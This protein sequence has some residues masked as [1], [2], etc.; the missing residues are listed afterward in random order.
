MKQGKRS[1]GRFWILVAMYIVIVSDSEAGKGARE[2]IPI[3]Q[4]AYDGDVD[5]VEKLIDEGA[6]VNAL[7]GEKG[8]T[9]LLYACK[10]GSDEVADLLLK[11]G[12]KMNYQLPWRQYSPLML[13]VDSGNT[14]VVYLLL[15]SGADPNL[16]DMYG[17]TALMRARAADRSEMVTQLQD[18]GAKEIDAI[19][20]LEELGISDAEA[21]RCEL[22]ELTSS[23]RKW[24]AKNYE[25]YK[26]KHRP[27]WTEIMPY[28]DESL[29]VYVRSGKDL[30]GNKIVFNAFRSG[31][32]PVT[33]SPKSAAS[34]E[35]VLNGKEDSKSFW[36]EYFPQESKLN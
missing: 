20:P 15:K 10:K 33:I 24:M 3:I 26:R 17:T 29:P 31:H 12:A 35:N 9:A 21:L 27:T 23:Y 6:D 19:R 13:A 28:V 25:L 34:L 2:D 14:N 8:W 36:G 32:L 1:G 11:A 4:A 16:K 18:H 30:L 22:A 7:T 5:V